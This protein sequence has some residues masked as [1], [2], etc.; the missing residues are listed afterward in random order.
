VW[1]G[2]VAAQ[3]AYDVQ[4][5]TT[6]KGS[7]AVG[8]AR[9]VTGAAGGDVVIRAENQ[10]ILLSANAGTTAHVV[11]DTQGFLGLGTSSPQRRLHLVGPESVVASFP[12]AA[13]G[14]RDLL[15]LE[16]ANNANLSFITGGSGYQ[17]IIRF[18]KS[19]DAG[20][21]GWISY[22]HGVSNYMAL[23]AGG[24]ERMRVESSGRI[25]FGVAAP[26]S[27][28]HQ[29]TDTAANPTSA[30]ISD[31]GGKDGLLT[32]NSTSQGAVGS[33]GGI[34]FGGYQFGQ[35]FAGIKSLLADGAGST[36]GHLAFATRNSATDPALTERMRITAN[37]RVGIGHQDPQYTLHVQ[38]TG[39]FEG[40]VSA[41]YQDVAEW[42]PATDAL[43]AGTVVV[44]DR[45]A[46]NRV[47]ASTTAYD[48]AVA[49]VISEQ[50]GVLL[51]V[52]GPDKVRV[53]T[54]GRVKVRADASNGP[55]AIG[56]LL[57]TS[58][59]AGMVMRS[60]PMTMN[61]RTF[62]QPGTLVGKALERLEKGSGEI[63]VLLSLQ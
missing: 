17:T 16:N 62:H 7:F 30:A 33:G 18:L 27:A 24:A 48:T 19:G 32:L 53:A 61:G 4:Q 21:T 47:T 12:S 38:G 56:D 14:P 35:F 49:G 52:E 36:T 45:S 5:G 20:A 6:V 44:I 43:S 51:G 57:V 40:G 46:P 60:E 13:M 59:T 22:M 63:L 58:K 26:I 50:P 25:G 8:D 41:V 37:G 31:A 9:S 23:A 42:V 29:Y 1:T 3:S 2:V 28:I 55:I 34:L 10:K 11:L 54:T 15:V 39:R